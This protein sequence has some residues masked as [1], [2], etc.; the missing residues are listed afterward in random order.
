MKKSAGVIVILKNKKFLLVHPT[1]HKWE[2]SFSFPKGGI[3]DG[4]KKI[5]A[6]IRELFEETSVVVT[7]EQIS[8]PKEPIVIK[9]TSRKGEVYKKVYL[10]TVYID[11]ISDIGLDSEVI[12]THKLQQSEVDWGGF[13]TRKESKKKIF[14]R[15]ND[16]LDMI[17]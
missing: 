13:M 2:N 11:D 17:K 7:K 1:G 12:E 6:A 15:V 8:N 9:Y 14:F 4:E 5:D 10:F 3:E 16:L